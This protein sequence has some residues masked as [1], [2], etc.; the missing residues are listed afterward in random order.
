MLNKVKSAVSAVVQRGK[1][2][3]KYERRVVYGAIIGF[4]V[5]FFVAY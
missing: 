5:G 4:A 1:D 2:I 3:W